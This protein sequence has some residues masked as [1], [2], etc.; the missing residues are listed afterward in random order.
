MGFVNKKKEFDYFNCF[1]SVGEIANEASETLHSITQSFDVSKI[2]EYSEVM[3]KFE[4]DADTK[5]HELCNNLA[6]EFMPPIEREDISLL[7]QELDNIVDSVED[8]MRRMYMFNIQKIRTDA[9]E[10]AK[11]INDASNVFYNL[12]L[13]FPHFKKSKK[14]HDLI[15]EINTIENKGDK[16]HA[17]SI[18]SLF[19]ESENPSDQLAW[20]KI[21]ESM[22][23][24]IDSIERA[25]DIIDSVVTKNT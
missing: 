9:I 16:L 10:F 6:H 23:N 21:F 20:T 12:L 14:L 19:Q 18:R 7:A 22:E 4:N 11:L 8:V 17:E 24:S 25:A 15:I 5:K 2:D 3:H 1:C 13:E